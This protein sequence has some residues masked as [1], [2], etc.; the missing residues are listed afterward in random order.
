MPTNSRTGIEIAFHHDSTNP[1]TMNTW[2]RDIVLA[3]PDPASPLALQM[4]YLPAHRLPAMKSATLRV[5][6]RV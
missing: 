4:R 2:N 1:E 3:T 6:C 5:N